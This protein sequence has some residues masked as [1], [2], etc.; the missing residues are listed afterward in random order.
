MTVRRRRSK[1]NQQIAWIET[2]A[3]HDPEVINPLDI[4]ALE[5]NFGGSQY[6]EEF[7]RRWVCSFMDRLTLEVL[8]RYPGAHAIHSTGSL[9]GSEGSKNSPGSA[10]P[11]DLAAAIE[12]SRRS[13]VA[14]IF[15]HGDERYGYIKLGVGAPIAATGIERLIALGAK[16]IIIAGTVGVLDPSIRRG[17]LI[18]AA[19]AIREE[20]TSY[21]YLPA[22]R[23]VQPSRKLMIALR[24]ALDILDYPHRTGTTWTTDAFYRETRDKIDRLRRRDRAICVEMEAAA[25]FAVARFRKVEAAGIFYASDAIG[26]E[27]WDFHNHDGVAPRKS[28]AVLLDVALKAFESIGS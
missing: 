20:G 24:G 17:D 28:R 2:P 8:N 16:Q 23:F 6:P 26:G 27:V 11:H 25:M 22:A 21:H 9:W 1:T 12:Q 15:E 10:P 5:Q 3:L 14:L 4:V 7:P 19:R 13:R 18:V